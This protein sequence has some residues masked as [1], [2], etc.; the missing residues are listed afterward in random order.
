VV[1]SAVVATAAV[2]FTAH[3]DFSNPAKVRQLAFK[4]GMLH[5]KSYT[6]R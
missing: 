2:M 3:P 5:I 6:S 1:V 4:N